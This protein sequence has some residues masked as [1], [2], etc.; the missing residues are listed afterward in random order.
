LPIAVSNSVLG[1]SPASL[2]FVAFTQT[3]TRIVLC[4]LSLYGNCCLH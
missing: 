1:I 4:L 3:S 2:A